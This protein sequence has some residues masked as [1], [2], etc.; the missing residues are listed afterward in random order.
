MNKHLKSAKQT[1][2]QNPFQF[3]MLAS[4]PWRWYA[5]CLDQWPQVNSSDMPP[6]F[7]KDPPMKSAGMRPPLC[8]LVLILIEICGTDFSGT[9]SRCLRV[10][11][12]H[13]NVRHLQQHR[14][15][16]LRALQN[17]QRK[18]FK[19]LVTWLHGWEGCEAGC[20]LN[21]LSCSKNMNQIVLSTSL[22]IV[23]FNLLLLKNYSTLQ[24]INHKIFEGVLFHPMS[25]ICF[26]SVLPPSWCACGKA[27]DVDVLPF[28]V[29]DF[30]PC[31]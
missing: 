14:T 3:D 20:F 17:L 19:L 26:S 27:A 8:S 5:C 30:S 13:G 1:S 25:V 15:D 21:R 18:R 10:L 4:R 2:N 12:L 23:D 6:L 24:Y 16:V 28:L 31:S 7:W 11:R 29:R 9:T 22:Q